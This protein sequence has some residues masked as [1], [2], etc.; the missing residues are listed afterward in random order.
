MTEVSVQVARNATRAAVEA[1]NVVLRAK[2]GFGVNDVVYAVR[3]ESTP[4][5]V[6]LLRYDPQDEAFEADIHDAPPYRKWIPV[7]DLEP[8]GAV[9]FQKCADRLQGPLRALEYRARKCREL[10]ATLRDEA[11]APDTPDR[12]PQRHPRVGDV[13]DDPRRTVGGFRVVALD[14]YLE[15]LWLQDTVTLDE[16]RYVDLSEW[17]GIGGEYT[18]GGTVA[19]AAEG[20]DK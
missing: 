15:G 3:G 17:V 11:E 1:W 4:V 6:V 10:A 13:C 8:D 19:S 9:A 7:A 16:P 2:Y 18:K 5:Q 12:D 14:P 20:G